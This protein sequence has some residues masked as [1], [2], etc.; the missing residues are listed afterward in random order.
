MWKPGCEIDHFWGQSAC[1]CWTSKMLMLDNIKLKLFGKYCY[2]LKKRTNR[3]LN[4]NCSVLFIGYVSMIRGKAKEYVQGQLY[5][6]KNFQKCFKK[7][8]KTLSLLLKNVANSSWIE[9][10]GS[11]RAQKLGLQH[12]RFPKTKMKC[13][14]WRIFMEYQSSFSKLRSDTKYF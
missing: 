8:I 6:F 13:F 1:Q 3:K 11:W 2:F 7:L 12:V 9:K 10:K 14:R 5:R 4:W